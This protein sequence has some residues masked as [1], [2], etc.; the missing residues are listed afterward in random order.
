MMS[1]NKITCPNCSFESPAHMNF[2]GRCGTR[3]GQ[4]CPACNFGNPPE[5]AFC[6]NCGTRLLDI[7]GQSGES[8]AP[9][10]ASQKVPDPA[11]QVDSKTPA[12]PEP[13][14]PIQPVSVPL[15]GIR[16][17]ATVVL[18]DVMGSTDLMARLGTEAWV[19][20]MNQVLQVLETEVYRFG[21]EVDQFRGDGL[22]AFFGATSVHEDD[23]E[24]AV[25]AGLAMQKSIQSYAAE[26]AETAGIEL[27]LRV[28]VNTGEVIVGSVGDSRQHSEETAMGEAVALAARMETA[29]EPGTV[30]VSEN[31]YNL[32]EPQFDWQALGEI[33]VKGMSRPIVVYRPLAPLADAESLQRML[34]HDFSIPLIGRDEAFNALK[35]QVLDLYDDRGGIALVTADKG[36]GKSF[37]VA[38]V[39][40]HL[41]R[42]DALIAEARLGDRPAPAP[43]TWLTG[44]CR[45]YNQTWPYSMWISLLKTWL[46]AREGEP[47][48][49]MR[50]RLYHRAEDLWGGQLSEHYPILVVILGLPLEEAF[51]DR[52]E[53][54]DAEGLSQQFALT[55]R[56][57]VDKMAAR[58]PLVLSFADMHWA[59]ATSLQLLK[60]C[61]P[62]CDHE[63]LLWLG[64]YRPDRGTPVWEFQHF[65]ETEYPHRTTTLTLDPLDEEES[66]ELIQRLIGADVLPAETQQ[67][68]IEKAEGVPY[69]LGEFIRSLIREGALVWDEG[70]GGWRA[71]RAVDSLI[72]PDSLQ[73]LLLARLDDLAA[74][75]HRVL[76][77]AAVIGS[78]FW[79]DVLEALVGEGADVKGYLTDLQRAGLITERGLVPDLGREYVFESNL[80]RDVSYESL[81]RSQRAAYHRQVAEYLEEVISPEALEGYAP[82]L[83]YHNRH[84]GARQR[85]LF[86]ILNA[87]RQAQ[88]F[89]ANA[90][91]LSAY[92]RALE[93]FD[94]IEAQEPE[95]GV[96]YAIQIERFEVLNG[97]REVFFR[98]G[99]FQAARADAIA[100]LPLARSM[101]AEPALVIDALLQQPGV[102]SWWHA[103][104]ELAAGVQLAREAL[105]L[106]QEIGDRHREMLCLYAVARQHLWE[107]DPSAWEVAERAL[108]LARELGDRSFEVQ[109]LIGMGS[110]CAWSDRPDEGMAYLEA[111]LP[112]SEALGDKIAQQRVIELIGLQHE[113][114]GDYYRLLTEHFQ[115][116]LKIGRE[117]GH[118]PIEAD[119]LRDCGQ[120]QGIYLGDLDGGMAL[121]EECL[122]IWKDTPTE[123]FA[124]LRIAQ[125]QLASGDIEAVEHTLTR[126]G[127]L[128]GDQ[129]VKEMGQAGLKLVSAIFYNQRQ[130]END[131]D[132]VLA[133]AAETRRLVVERPLT[134]QY[135]MAATCQAS[136][137]HLALAERSEDEETRQVHLAAALES[138]ETALEIYQSFGFVQIIECLSEEILFRH[139]LALKANGNQETAAD[140]LH[141]AYHEMMRKHALIPDGHPFRE[142]YLENIPLHRQIRAAHQAAQVAA[143]Q[144]Q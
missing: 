44:R 1:S 75:A 133:L 96:L 101:D 90:E 39:R 128:M 49:E 127:Y 100:L 136:E 12:A 118:R 72:L 24:R 104:E 29:A 79:S 99:D 80:V 4:V 95:E 40:Q 82:I 37:L 28:G 111:A 9:P 66:C 115:V 57:W 47:E 85:E 112:I 131:L 78:V 59:D 105:A 58:G 107:D 117:I 135:E 6:G 35:D 67:L 70:Q 61:L 76:Q 116:K 142:T 14:S 20:M 97:R 63:P 140:F 53:H 139:A 69:Y 62:V 77:V 73:S 7:L 64:V 48:E 87:A 108:A 38:R 34:P 54:L 114:N 102:S 56:S 91:A 50:G 60:Y 33:T 123:P 94:E 18:A 122:E 3:L 86:Y 30:L 31:T 27:L 93:L 84:A 113:R 25:L 121:L 129:D 74:D 26:L 92:N 65:V 141:R 42:H 124:L 130:T 41:H 43:V 2:C 98:L 23:P 125:I 88:H 143:D 103:P 132:K 119:A 134:R 138:S 68:I 110:V 52:I 13:I 71:T 11:H 55:V 45:S 5:Y 17:L 106:A 83:A 19:E 46:E 144:A 36:L 16:R 126:T 21:G 137:A 51:T 120:T 89:N 81:L 109:I 8:P 10:A 15:S 22:V 32:I